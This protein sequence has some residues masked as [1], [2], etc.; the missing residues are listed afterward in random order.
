MHACVRVCAC[1]CVCVCVCVCDQVSA[2]VNGRCGLKDKDLRIATV[3]FHL[4]AD[5]HAS[6][7]TRDFPIGCLTLT[8][9]VR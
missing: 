6:F 1:M 9:K 4:D 7:T 3:C 2:I 8:E 5:D